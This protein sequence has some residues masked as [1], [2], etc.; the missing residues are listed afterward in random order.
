MEITVPIKKVRTF[1]K[2]GMEKNIYQCHFS[3]EA[4]F[5]IFS[6]FLELVRRLLGLEVAASRHRISASESLR[7]HLEPG[8]KVFQP[9]SGA[10][11]ESFP[12]CLQL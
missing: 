11:L 8:W 5:H 9:A 3:I 7:L 10:R 12:T 4:L 1:F 6:S 2:G